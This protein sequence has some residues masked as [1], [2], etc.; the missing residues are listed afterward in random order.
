MMSYIILLD[1]RHHL[2]ALPFGVNKYHA[3][4]FVF[5][6]PTDPHYAQLNIRDV[7]A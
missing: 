3:I 6:L 1:R 7:P 2:T 4:V 5:I